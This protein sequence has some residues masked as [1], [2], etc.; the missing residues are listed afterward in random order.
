M[1]HVAIIGGG[2]TG[3][4]AAY[5][6]EQQQI[7]YTLIEVKGQLGG[8]IASERR[9]G[10]LIDGGMMAILGNGDWLFLAELGLSDAV[11]RLPEQPGGDYFAFKQGT[12]TLVDALA[13][14]LT[15]QVMLR[16]AVSSL[17]QMDNHFTICLENGLMLTAS[18]LIVAAPARYAERMFRSLQPE[19]AKRLANY[20]YDTIMRVSLGFRC[21]DIRLPLELPWDVAMA[22][23]NWT[24]HPS[25]VP[26][27]HLLIQLGIRIPPHRTTPE[28]LVATLQEQLG[29]PPPVTSL[30]SHWP[31]ADPLTCLMP[32]HRENMDAIERL[33]PE[34]AALVGSDYRAS[35]FEER[36]TQGREAARKIGAL[37]A[38][39]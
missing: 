35:S 24:D 34:R 9:D 25:R 8:G 3:L 38:K 7:P 17:G 32:G 6:L 22:S 15:G 21:E 31:E 30:V 26:P 11:Y 2:L 5:E 1:S 4:A 27:D 23:A 39:K 18:A 29:W 13:S 12:Q 28:S 33:L 37:L 10:F 14:S 19:I 36:V 16:M 20:R